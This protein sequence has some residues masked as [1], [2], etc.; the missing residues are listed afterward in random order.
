MDPLLS[1]LPHWA[2]VALGSNLGDRATHLDLARKRLEAS[3]CR[4]FARSS[5]Y[6]TQPWGLKQQPLF[7]N[8]VIGLRT[9][10]DP[11]ELL[12][13]LQEL[14]GRAGRKRDIPNGPR[15]LDLD[16]LN[17]DNERIL[18]PELQLPHPRLH[19]RAFVLIPLEEIAPTLLL[20]GLNA[21]VAALAHALSEEE[22]DTVRFWLPP[23]PKVRAQL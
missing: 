7:L 10:L 14:E 3:G 5:I 19:Q 12:D 11:F 13:L 22:R 16:L 9:R 20:P 23:A 17:W 1:Y 6:E 21:S 18:V 2:Y 15:T 8:Q 4:V